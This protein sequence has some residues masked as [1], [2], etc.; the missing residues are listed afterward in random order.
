M[1][2]SQIKEATGKNEDFTSFNKKMAMLQK[3]TS[4]L[5][6]VFFFVSFSLRYLV[7]MIGIL[8]VVFVILLCSSFFEMPSHLSMTEGC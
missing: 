6:K 4:S 3:V 7:L 5:L 1:S 8:Y 2:L